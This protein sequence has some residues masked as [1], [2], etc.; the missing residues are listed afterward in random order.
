M[1]DENKEKADVGKKTVQ[2]KN[3]AEKAKAS[4]DVP[5]KKK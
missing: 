5:G 3:D 1:I 4:T 2:A